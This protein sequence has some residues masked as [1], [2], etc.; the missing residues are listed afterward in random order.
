[1]TLASRVARAS[2]VLAVVLLVL[3]TP[4]DATGTAPACDGRPATLVGI[5]GDDV[6]TGTDGPDV[7]VGL[8]GRDE[9]TGPVTSWISPMSRGSAPSTSTA[10]TA[11]TGCSARP[12]S[13]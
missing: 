2:V 12:V 3:P 11:T 7:I 5:E 10:A 8:G 9:I 6:L 1:V 4:A 13:T